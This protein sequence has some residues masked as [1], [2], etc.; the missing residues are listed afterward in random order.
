MKKT[1]SFTEDMPDFNIGMMQHKSNLFCTEGMEGNFMYDYYLIGPIEASSSEYVEMM[2][3]LRSLS[4]NDVFVIHINCAGGSVHA[5]EQILS[6]MKDSEGYI[7]ASIEG[8][9]SSMAT[10]ICLHSDEVIISDGS[11][12]LVHNLSAGA[13][14]NFTSIEDTTAYLKSL[15]NHLAE[16]YSS[17]LTPEELSRVQH[18]RDVTLFA[19]EVRK[20]LETFDYPRRKMREAR[21]ECCGEEQSFSLEDMIKQ[22]VAEG[23]KQHEAEKAKKEAKAKKAAVK[24]KLSVDE[25]VKETPKEFFKEYPAPKEIVEKVVDTPESDT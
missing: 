4:P 16:L 11:M 18:G 10:Q 1:K 2:Q 15:N 9:A 22:A 13:I 23:I 7:V 8:E 3:C 19:A 12:F 24:K 17:L 14:G 25:L 20:R 5:G 21:E 6:A